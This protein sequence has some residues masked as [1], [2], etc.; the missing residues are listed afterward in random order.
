[1]SNLEDTFGVW[2]KM[3]LPNSGI[4]ERDQRLGVIRRFIAT[5][6]KDDI[7][8][9]VFAFYSA[10]T[11][12]PTVH[13]LR[14]GMR[15]VDTSFGAKDDAEL[16]VLAA[17]VLFDIFEQG[18]EL[19]VTAALAILCADFGALA[20]SNHITE[21]VA[22]ARQFIGT[23]GIRIREESI[24]LP[25]LGEALRSALKPEGD[26]TEG[27]DAEEEE[28]DRDSEANLHRVVDVLTDYGDKVKQSLASIE[29]RR[30]EQSDILYW[31]LS[32]RRHING[33]PLKGLKKEQVALFVAV[34]LANLTRQ[35]PGPA[36]ASAILSTLLDQC[37]NSNAG[38]VTLEV[39]VQSIDAGDGAEYLAKRKVVHPVISPVSF[40]LIKA[41]ETGW[42]DGWQNAV[43]MQ[44]RRSVTTKYPVLKIAE[45][46]YREVLLSRT[47]GVN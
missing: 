34:E 22:K 28:E 10:P 35:I 24:K 40:A 8:N 11:E 27:T 29:A 1:M 19:A 44:T 3:V 42:D 39:C 2:L 4:A 47:L 18:G 20:D 21:L 14:S 6:N 26:G 15:D 30:A 13:R 45:Q 33:V 36:S 12:Q 5:V 38:E 43:K 7:L 16:A 41:E 37:A 31:L 25:N 46:L 17:G 23:E 32:G 9:I